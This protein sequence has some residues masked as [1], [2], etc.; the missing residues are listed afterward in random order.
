MILLVA[1]GPF[2]AFSGVGSLATLAAIAAGLAMARVVYVMQQQYQQGWLPTLFVPLGQI[3]FAAVLLF[4]SCK[5]VIRGG[6]RWRND[7]YSNEAIRAGRR[8]P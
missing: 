1:M 6:V 4:V 5:V 2:L 7:F 3:A 8:L